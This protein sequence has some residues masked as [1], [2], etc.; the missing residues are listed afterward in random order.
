MEKG[1]RVAV[2][3][4][5]FVELVLCMIYGKYY[6]RG[7][8]EADLLSVSFF[9]CTF[10]YCIAPFF[11]KNSKASGLIKFDLLSFIAL[12]L[13]YLLGFRLILNIFDGSYIKY[14][15]IFIL[16]ILAIKTIMNLFAKYKSS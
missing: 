9:V 15:A 3:C 13:I 2:G 16:I 4:I 12:L 7:W 8:S 1:E 5:S 10:I 11:V 6:I 14:V